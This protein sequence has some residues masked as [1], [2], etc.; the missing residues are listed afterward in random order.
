MTTKQYLNQ[1]R[2]ARKDVEKL[3]SQITNKRE[4]LTSI[5]VNSSDV[6]VQSSS[7][8]DKVASMVA[9]ILDMESELKDYVYRLITLERKISREIEEV[10]GQK[11]RDVLFWRYVQGYTFEKTADTMA[12]SYM[13]TIRIHGEALL[14]FEKLFG[15]RYKTSKDVIECYN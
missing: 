6:R 11:Y 13:Q 9:T 12:Y 3:Q 5:S 2:N 15:D 7:D 10:E 14:E 4:L 1:I 8:P